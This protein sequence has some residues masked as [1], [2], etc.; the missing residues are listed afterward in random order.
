MLF[1][2]FFSK[3]LRRPLPKDKNR[4][5]SSDDRG[6]LSLHKV[7]TPVDA[8]QIGMYVTELDKPWL[9]SSFLFQGFEVKSENDILELKRECN[10]VYI[11]VTRQSKLR[12]PESDTQSQT[13]TNANIQSNGLGRKSLSTIDTEIERAESI[14]LDT[15][16]LVVD[17]MDKIAKGGSVD[18]GLAKQAVSECVDSVLHSPDAVIWLSQLKHRH[19]YT[20]QHSMNVCVLSIVLGR[21]VNM[22]V[23]ELN[24]VGLCG[25]MH[26]MGKM[27]IPLE[28]ID[29]P[30]RLDD[31]ELR[32]MQTHPTLG[33]ELL[34]SSHGM[35]E[36]AVDTAHDHHERLD[37]LGYPRKIERTMISRYTR[38]VTIADM[39]DAIT[40]DRPYQNGRTHL[41]AT[42]IM[43]D[44]AG[45]H[46][47]ADLLYKF[48][49]S[50]GVYPPGCFVK[51]TNDDIAIIVEVNPELKLRPKIMIVQDRERQP[52]PEKVLDLSKYPTDILGEV[53]MIRGVIKPGDYGIDAYKY[54]NK[55][56]IQKGFAV[57]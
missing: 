29:K 2:G 16:S 14:I 20:A 9:E 17:F 18:A 33:Y 47:D 6:Y 45:K 10:Y 40:S 41:E 31:E 43:T 4:N 30:G 46:L 35:Y 42:K 57:A 13:E 24:Q 7:Y 3:I 52:M 36:G 28:I 1:G 8:I 49:E 32:I 37:K 26:D 54:Y 53:Y 19:E 21:Q 48:I 38:I 23:K 22:N 34:A 51:M 50:L 15:R 11:D 39:Y 5:V 27:L 12:K 56:V 25:M 55:G 44:L